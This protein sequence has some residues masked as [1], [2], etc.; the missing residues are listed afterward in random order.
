MPGSLLTKTVLY[1]TSASGNFTYDSTDLEIASNTARL[2]LQSNPSQT[3]T[4]DFA[5][6]TGFTYTASKS[7][8][9]GTLTQDDQRPAGATFFA[10]YD[11]DINGNWGDGTTT[12][13]GTGSPTI[14]SNTLD[15]TGGTKYV[16]YNALSNASSAQTLCVRMTIIPN[17]TGSP[18]TKQGLFAISKVA[19]TRDNGI[20]L[21][22]DSGGN[23]L[24]AIYNDANGAISSTNFGAWSPTA[25]TTY[26][27]EF[28]MDITTGATRLFIDGT[29]KGS[30]IVST[31]TR[32]SANIGLLR[33][34]NTWNA[35]LSSSNFKV[36]YIQIFSA[37]QHTG[38]YSAPSTVPSSTIYL[39]DTITCPTM[40]YSTVGDVQ[41][42][43]SFTAT[44]TGS[45]SYILNGK[46]WDDPAWA[47]STGPSESTSKA[48]VNTNIGSL[49][50][51][52]TL[53][54]KV[55][56]ASS[57]TQGIVDDIVVGYTGQIYA[58]D[59]P[60]MIQ[61]AGQGVGADGLASFSSSQTDDSP[62]T[63][64]YQMSLDGT[65]KYWNGS[66]WATSDGTYS[67]ANTA[68]EINTNAS[69]LDLSA[70]IDEVLVRAVFSSDGQTRSLLTSVSFDYNFFAEAATPDECVIYAF[71]GDL[72]G[73]VDGT[74]VELSIELE[75]SFFYSDT[76]TLMQ[77]QDQRFLPDSNGMIQASVVETTTDSK[78]YHFRVFYK[79]QSGIQKNIDLG[80]AAVPNSSNATLASL[81]FSATE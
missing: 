62:A 10:S 50:A 69:S 1:S 21:D 68:A 15:L 78:K 6:D 23:I 58:T 24:I 46:F 39:Q 18:G 81:T 51:S 26:E 14:T 80:Y 19:D 35:S 70:G 11:S 57:N 76:A 60:Y 22:H 17:Y 75:T 5:D 3:F 34:G 48:D 54:V 4:E 40:T 77:P 33:I 28:N 38:N 45:V 8:I 67:Q 72:L 31:G 56:T 64:K 30:T 42:F 16:S 49:P 55:V 7:T 66:A 43:T 73:N 59:N 61:N 37:V 74:D 36:G 29:Q 12:G 25:G 65:L 53:A 32:N 2:K 79:D 9:S 27:F 47:T 41:A 13:T 44:E 20:L 63:I 71:V 52:D